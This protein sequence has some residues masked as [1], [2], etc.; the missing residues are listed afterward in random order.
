MIAREAEVPVINKNQEYERSAFDDH[1]GEMNASGS[2][3]EKNPI[4]A[5]LNQM[6]LH[7]VKAF[8]EE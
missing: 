5:S 6:Q 2:D 8:S 1:D 7:K 4:K 3:S